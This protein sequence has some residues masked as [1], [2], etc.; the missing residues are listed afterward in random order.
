[1]DGAGVAAG[2]T[3]FAPL[4]DNRMLPMPDSAMRR[5]IMLCYPLI[6]AACAAIP[7]PPSSVPD[8]PSPALPVQAGSPL[9]L[10]SIDGF[11]NDYLER[12]LTPVL[13]TLADDGVRADFMR[14]SFPSI[15]FPNHYTLVTG[16]RP[17]RHGVVANFMTDP[18]RPGAR[19]SMFDRESVSDAFWWNGGK[20]LWSS[21]REH[22]GRAATMFWVG[23]EAPVHGAHPEFWRPFDIK[24]GSSQRVAQVLQWLAL[25]PAQRPHFLT[26]YFDAVDTAGHRHGPDSP[27]LEAALAQV[28][29]ALGELVAGIRALGLQGQVNLVIVSDHGMAATSPERELYLDDVVDSDGFDLLWTGA[30][31]SFDAA[32]DAS[33]AQ[34][35]KLLGEHEHFTCMTRDAIPARFAFGHHRRVPEYFCLAEHGWQVTTREAARRKGHRLYGEHGYDHEHPD[36]RSPFIAHGPAFRRGVT[37]APIDNVD[38]YPLLARL[39]GIAPEQNDGNPESTRAAL[40]QAAH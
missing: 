11:R 31:A 6:F 40:A 28:D 30:Y 2:V 3:A 20:P 12:G 37:I 29:T 22:G 4:A 1:M 19:F 8:A 23:S 9:I 7:A 18:Q 36:M 32:T 21:V 26:L 33:R 15:T 16:L 17:D 39:L 10:I 27:E 38:V 14:P 13:Q 35:R 34:A 25:P 24:I 5:L